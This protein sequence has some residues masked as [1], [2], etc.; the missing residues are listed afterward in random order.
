MALPRASSK[1]RDAPSIAQAP[2]LTHTP[3]HS[4]CPINAKAAHGRRSFRVAAS[5]KIAPPEGMR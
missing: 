1:Q 4:H 3:P 2:L 5:H